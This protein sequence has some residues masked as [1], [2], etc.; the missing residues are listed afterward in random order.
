MSLW[1]KPVDAITFDDI[2]IFCEQ[3]Q[4]EGPRLDYKLDIPNDFE[5][6]VAAFANTLGGLIVL[7]VEAD[8]TTN[9]PVWP[10]TR[11][12]PKK[13]GIEERITAIC[14][15]R[16]YPPLRPQISS[17]ID[18]P[19]AAEIALAVLRVEESPEAPHAVNGY[20]Y[21][22]TGSQGTPYTLSHIERIA[23][24]LAR[25]GRIEEQRVEL[26]STELKREPPTGRH[27]PD[28]RSKRSP[29]S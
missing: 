9:K 23:H 19:H 27:T 24:L 7:G 6:V 1:S 14:R 26:V 13:H 25:R 4:S 10:P 20:I 3:Q 8:K 2:N 18:N 16:I 15:D 12:M 29:E 28:A 5:K 22:R 17:I 21:E 11:G